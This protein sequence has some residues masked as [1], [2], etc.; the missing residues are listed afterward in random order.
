MI[1]KL[2][3][4]LIA[5]LHPEVRKTLHDYA[6][7]PNSRNEAY[8]VGYLTAAHTFGGLLQDHHEYLLALTARM[9]EDATLANEVFTET[10]ERK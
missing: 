2:N 3:Y 9:F 5:G 4:P 8:M 10:I 1:T 6:R 7:F